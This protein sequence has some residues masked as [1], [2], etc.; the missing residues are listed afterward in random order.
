MSIST[1]INGVIQH[2]TITFENKINKEIQ[3]K[4]KA[5]ITGYLEI[6]K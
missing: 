1:R 6:A 3:K 4:E 5:G 2:K